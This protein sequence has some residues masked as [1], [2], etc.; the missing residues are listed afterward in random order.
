MG[1]KAVVLGAAGGIGQPCACAFISALASCY[2]IVSTLNSNT[3]IQLGIINHLAVSLL[4][5]QSQVLTD[6][7]LFDVVPSVI[8]VGA[9]LSQ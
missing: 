3:D 8:G 7:A 6:L 2:G 5:K 9:D 4:L 1:K